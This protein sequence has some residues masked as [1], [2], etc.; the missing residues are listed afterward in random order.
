[1]E[2]A[3]GAEAQKQYTWKEIEEKVGLSRAWVQKMEDKGFIQ[4]SSPPG[5][6]RVA[7]LFTDWEVVNM[8]RLAA[9]RFVGFDPEHLHSYRKLVND[10]HTILQKYTKK[11]R[12]KHSPV[13]LFHIKDF[14]PDGFDAIPWDSISK[15]DRT[16]MKGYLDQALSECIDI[17]KM[18]KKYRQKTM[19]TLESLERTEKRLK[20]EFIDPLNDIF[21]NKLKYGGPE[22]KLW[23]DVLKMVEEL[24]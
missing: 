6:G 2:D 20:G 10:F 22:T 16:L 19:S 15:V 24:E 12:W 18:I 21:F 5:K 11:S 17:K 1:V 3:M 13:F 9:F 8:L 7:R 23:R 4:I 14:F